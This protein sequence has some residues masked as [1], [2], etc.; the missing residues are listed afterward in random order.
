MGLALNWQVQ[1]QEDNLS[2]LKEHIMQQAMNALREWIVGKAKLKFW[3]NVKLLLF[4][5]WVCSITVEAINKFACC[6]ISVQY[7]PNSEIRHKV[8]RPEKYKHDTE[9]SQTIKLWLRMCYL[10][11]N[12][13]MFKLVW[14]NVFFVN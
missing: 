3:F 2:C 14:W 13:G 8:K 11:I 4:N 6:S 9:Q 7:E 10:K 5:Y 12:I 1:F